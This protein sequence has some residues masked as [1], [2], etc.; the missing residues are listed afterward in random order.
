MDSRPSA[1]ALERALPP[2]TLLQRFEIGHVLAETAS[3]IDYLATD[4]QRDTQVVVK[5]YFPQ[6]LARRV[7]EE[8][9][10]REPVDSSPLALGLQAFM[11]EAR[12]LA[13]VD[14]P[15]LVRVSHVIEAH[16]TAY[17]VLPRYDGAVTLLDVRAEMRSPPDE[18]S[19]RALIDAKH[20]FV[21]FGGETENG[22]RKFCGEYTGQGLKCSSAGTGPAPSCCAVSGSA[23][24]RQWISAW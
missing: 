19:V 24:P 9:V 2:G 5:E 21:P 16:G 10:P 4:L 1:L 22:F 6:R 12:L 23:Q 15:S 20:P 14:H 13:R 8:M 7:R 17:Q 3:G 11:T 18:R